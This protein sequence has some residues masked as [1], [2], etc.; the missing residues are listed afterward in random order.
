LTNVFNL[1]ELALPA[2]RHSR[3]G[4]RFLNRSLGM[5]LGASMLSLGCYELGPGEGAGAFHYELTRE[6]WLLVITGEVTLRTLAGERIL[7]SGDIVCFRPG[8]DGAH[9][10]RN[11]GDSPA[12]FVMGSTK[13]ESRAIVYP[14]SDRMAVIGPG[15]KRMMK[16][17]DDL[18]YW[19][20][21]P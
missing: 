11:A 4:H 8:A 3:A 5:E 7:R 13:E 16:I 18:E 2:A 21:E 17:G 10:M 12:R 1:A 9:S 20:G 19:E 14:D 15:F 6:E